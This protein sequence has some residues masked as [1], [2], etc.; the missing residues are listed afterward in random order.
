MQDGTVD[1]RFSVQLGKEDDIVSGFVVTHDLPAGKRTG[2]GKAHRSRE[3]RG[4]RL[5]DPN[6]DHHYFASN[7]AC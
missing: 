1:V 3:N 6:L 7:Q 2:R 5:K 4:T